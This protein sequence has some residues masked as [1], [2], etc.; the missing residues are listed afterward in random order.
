MDSDSRREIEALIPHRDPFL[1]VD[2]ILERSENEIH[3]EWCAREDLEAF[4]G[5]YP[6][7]PILPGV[8]ISEF[9]FQSSALLLADPDAPSVTEGGPVPVLTKIENARY[10]RMVRPG[11]TLRAQVTL[12][13]SVGNARYLSAKVQS[14]SETVLRI[15]FVV[16]EVPVPAEV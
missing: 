1:L 6:G 10:K 13:E 2:K 4:R 15:R 7:Y 9:V 16:A 5:H 14:G 3:T 11:E 12:N 8:L